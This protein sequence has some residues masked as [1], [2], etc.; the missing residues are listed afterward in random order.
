[1]LTIDIE[2]HIEFND[3][4]FVIKKLHDSHAAKYILF[5]FKSGQILKEHETSSSIS[6]QVISGKI[7]FFLGEISSQIGAGEFIFLEPGKL[8]AI[9]AK[10]DSVVLLTLTPSPSSHTLLKL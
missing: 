6:V 2:K 1:M 8:H 10:E 3:E 9:K 4:H 7:D 5:C